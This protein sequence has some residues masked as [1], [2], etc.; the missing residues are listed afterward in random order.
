M[1]TE[2][3]SEFPADTALARFKE[4][5]GGVLKVSKSDLNRMLAEEKLAKQR[6]GSPSEVT[7]VSDPASP[8]KD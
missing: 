6:L 1:A 3:R 8:C 2:S 7:L 4:A 5:L